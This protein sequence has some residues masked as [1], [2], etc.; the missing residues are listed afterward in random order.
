[1]L[2]LLSMLC[3]QCMQQLGCWVIC[4][5][6]IGLFALMLSR[7]V[8][9]SLGCWLSP[10]MLSRMVAHSLGCWVISLDAV[11]NGG[12]VFSLLGYLP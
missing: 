12:S 9:W 8:A 11:Q 4:L 7:M 6:D 10:L 5:E 1:M 3:S 2:F